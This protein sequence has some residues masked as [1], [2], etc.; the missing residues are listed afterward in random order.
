ME[1]GYDVYVKTNVTGVIT[2][3]NSS[4]FIDDFTS[5]TLLEQNVQGDR[6]HHAQ[7]N[8]FPQPIMTTEGVYRY[9]L[10]KGK[11]KERTSKELQAD[12]DLIPP[13]PPTIQE[14]LTELKAK[15]AVMET[16]TAKLDAIETDLAEVKVKLKPLEPIEEVRVSSKLV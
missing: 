6:G 4:A 9:K 1:Y 13:P 12:I 8:Y 3:I 15:L 11:V 16:K 5:W 14:E 10:V 2:A 7:G